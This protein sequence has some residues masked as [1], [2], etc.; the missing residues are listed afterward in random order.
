M[1][2]TDSFSST[3]NSFEGQSQ[4]PSGMN[5]N[6][7]LSMR[8]PEPIQVYPIDLHQYARVDKIHIDGLKR[9]KD[10][11]IKAQ[12][13][14]LFAAKDFY[15]IIEQSQKVKSKL[16]TL[17]CFKNIGVTIDTSKGPDATPDGVEVTFNVRE[18]KWLSGGVNTMV[19]N[20]EGSLLIQAET[21][22]IFG[23]GERLKMDYSYGS[24]SSSNI[25]IS[26]VKPF[27]DNWLHKV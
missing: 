9:T 13:N 24:K 27:V 22:N 6:S 23:R 14:E 25:N 11:I 26:A 7:D 18:L 21:P 20:N 10:D 15:N 5:K 16:E 12:V 2:P 1:S 19:G 4:W 8:Q 3:T 17:G